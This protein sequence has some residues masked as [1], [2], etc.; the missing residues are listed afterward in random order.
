MSKLIL[1]NREGRER[2]KKEEARASQLFNRPKDREEE[3]EFARRA[4]H[5]S[6][7]PN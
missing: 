7:F 3:E 5:I 6:D 4:D 2:W 1:Y